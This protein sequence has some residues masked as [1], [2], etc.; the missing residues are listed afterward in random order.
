MPQD[1]PPE[2][3]AASRRLE[4]AAAWL[5]L[6]EVLVDEATVV[7]VAKNPTDVV[8]AGATYE[9]WNLE[10]QGFTVSEE[11]DASANAT[12][13]LAHPSAALRALLEAH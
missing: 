2:L 9:G 8:F 3:I 12:I 10:L 4:S 11:E 6:F 7:R 13:R 1:T 5:W